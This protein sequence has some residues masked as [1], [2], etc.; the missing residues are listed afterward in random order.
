MRHVLAHD[1]ARVDQR[2]VY[3]TVVD[4]L[5]DLLRVVSARLASNR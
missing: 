5:Q 2:V 1:Y 4:D 3:R